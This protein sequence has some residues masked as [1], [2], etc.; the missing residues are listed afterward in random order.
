MLQPPTPIQREPEPKKTKWVIKGDHPL[1]AILR[2]K[3]ACRLKLETCP[4]LERQGP[5]AQLSAQGWLPLSFLPP[6]TRGSLAWLILVLR[7]QGRM[8]TGIQY[9]GQSLDSVPSINFW[10]KFLACGGVRV[11]WEGAAQAEHVVYF[12]RVL[13]SGSVNICL[14]TEKVTTPTGP[15]LGWWE[16]FPSKSIHLLGNHSLLC[17]TPP[18]LV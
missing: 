9:R 16:S 1:N 15:L 6:G 4:V 17:T 2:N 11:G 12:Q 8:S 3:F 14:A 18:R 7:I 5:R 10:W 13:G